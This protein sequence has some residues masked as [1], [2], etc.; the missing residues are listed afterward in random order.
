M[1]AILNRPSRVLQ[2]AANLFPLVAFACA[3]RADIFQWEY[4]NPADPSQGKRQSTTVAPDGTGV[5]AVPGANLSNRNLTMA[6]LI[7]ADL[8]GAVGIA[9]N[10]TDADLSHANFGVIYPDCGP[11]LLCT[12]GT[13]AILTGAN[14]A[15][16]NV[17]DASFDGANL[18]DANFTGA[19]FQ[20]ASFDRVGICLATPYFCGVEGGITL[21]QLY[22]TA[23][24]QAHD[25][26]GIGLS[27]NELAGGNFVGQNLTNANFEW[28]TLGPANFR[29]ANLTDA[30]FNNAELTRADFR[31]ADLTNA[32]FHSGSLTSADFREANLSN[33]DFGSW[34][35]DGDFRRGATLTGATFRNANL[36][37]ASF[38]GATLTDADFTGAEI[39]GV[40]FSIYRWYGPSPPPAGPYGTGISL[41]QFY[42]T[43]SYQAQDLSGIGLR[44]NNLA[45]GNFTG[46][47]LTNADFGAATLTGANFRDANLTNAGFASFSC[48]SLGCFPKYF[49]I[50]TGADFSAADARGAYGPDLSAATT[51]NLILPNGHIN[52]LGL[53]AG[54][55]LVVRDYDGPSYNPELLIPIT[56]DQHLAMGPGGTLRMVFE[57]DAGIRPSPSRPASRSRSAARWNSSS[58]P[59]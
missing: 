5:D 58:P 11:F 24:Y 33:A 23:S 38:R 3:A 16:A 9:T 34:Y 40:D 44:Y 37:S 21:A 49:A 14:F 59:T 46:Q 55:R 31:E 29:E 27:F 17:R 6:Y 48:S 52:G 20:G 36:H 8:T 12:G 47:N 13:R 50:V 18:A 10:L 56:I 7:G 15:N 42:S 1:N 57:A 22:S 19:K 2:I 45:G 30:Y 4:I 39:R 25:L 41:T 35:Y 43:S 32:A 28:A 54:G 26:S 51:S 53:D